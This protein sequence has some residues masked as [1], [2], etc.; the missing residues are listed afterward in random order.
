MLSKAGASR[1]LCAA[2]QESMVRSDSLLKFEYSLHHNLSK[3]RL[4][5]TN[6]MSLLMGHM[7]FSQ[8]IWT[9]TSMEVRDVRS[10]RMSRRH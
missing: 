4:D 1:V 5:Q 2:S 10:K 8:S 7:S 6:N 3:P 9:V